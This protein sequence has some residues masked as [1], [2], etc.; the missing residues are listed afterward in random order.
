[1]CFASGNAAILSPENEAAPR[2]QQREARGQGGAADIPFSKGFASGNA[3]LRRMGPTSHLSFE[4]QE[5]ESRRFEGV[6]LMRIARPVDEARLQELALLQAAAL[7]AQR[8]ARHEGNDATYIEA[9]R[10]YG[11]YE[12]E[13]QL[14]LPDDPDQRRYLRQVTTRQMNAERERLRLVDRMMRAAARATTEQP[15]PRGSGQSQAGA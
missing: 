3:A 8:I 2:G 11:G 9:G 6:P 13:I 7:D 5:A 10:D 12:A 15:T 1:M 4:E 14:L